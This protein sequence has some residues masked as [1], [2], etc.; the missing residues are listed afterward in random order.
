MSVS[1]E[2]YIGYTIEI[3]PDVDKVGW[4]K[5]HNFEDKY[6]EIDKY[7]HHWEEREGKVLLVADGMCGTFARLIWV[8][9]YKDEASLGD[10]NEYFKLAEAE[11]EDKDHKIAELTKYYRL[12]T[13]DESEPKI[14][15]A[16]WSLWG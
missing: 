12:Y 13:G 16:M 3:E 11:C 7:N 9:K 6:P 15:Y 4:K 5:I 1:S 10:S 2:V 14:E 8:D